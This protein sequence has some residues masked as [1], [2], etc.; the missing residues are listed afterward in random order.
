V[1]PDSISAV[2]LARGQ[3][4]A[5]GLADP[6]GQYFT[7]LNEGDTHALEDVWP[8]EVVIYDPHAGEVRGHRQVRQFVSRNLSWLAGLRAADS[9]RNSPTHAWTWAISG[10]NVDAREQARGGGG[11]NPGGIDGP[12]TSTEGS[13]A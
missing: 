13:G 4:R 3:T 6:A 10:T 9:A 5:A 1:F 12:L 11:P 2:E 8:G 7:A